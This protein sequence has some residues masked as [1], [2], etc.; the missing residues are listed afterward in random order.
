MKKWVCLAKYELELLVGISHE[1]AC[2]ELIQWSQHK[3]TTKKK[4]KKNE[5]NR[6]DKPREIM[7]IK[8]MDENQVKSC[9]HVTDKLS[10]LKRLG[11]QQ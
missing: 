3:E 5:K 7:N 9:S 11:K 8:K 6:K 10:L 4:K 1:A 2:L